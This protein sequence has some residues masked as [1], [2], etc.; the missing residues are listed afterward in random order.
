[1]YLSPGAMKGGFYPNGF[2][3]DFSALLWYGRLR[4]QEV[5]PMTAIPHPSE[6][7]PSLEWAGPAYQAYRLLQV[8]FVAAPIIAGIDKFTD[9]LV[10]WDQYLA[11]QVAS[12]VPA[13]LF[14]MIAGIIEIIAGVG[15]AIKPRY[16]GYIVAAWLVGII[17]NLL[18]TGHYFDIALRDLGLCLGALALARL[19]QHYDL[20]AAGG[21]MRPHGRA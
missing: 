17:I 11:P 1:V 5:T 19:A 14:M 8:G 16:F 21:L 10:N 2:S 4:I 18:M 12:V 15:I 3:G 9:K 7:A 20:G 6:H 13:H